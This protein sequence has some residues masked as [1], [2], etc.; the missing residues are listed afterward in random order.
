[1]YLNHSTV[2]FLYSVCFFYQL[3]TIIMPDHLAMSLLNVLDC[4]IR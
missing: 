1:M 2:C 3:T 4:D